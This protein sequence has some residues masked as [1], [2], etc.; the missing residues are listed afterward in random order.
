MQQDRWRTAGL[1]PGMAVRADI[2][3]P[4]AGCRAVDVIVHIICAHRWRGMGVG[5]PTVR[6]P[7]TRVVARLM[8][9][10]SF[11]LL[12]PPAP[13]VGLGAHPPS[14]FPPSVATVRRHGV[15]VHIVGAIH[16]APTSARDVEETVRAAEPSAVVLEL[17]GPRWSRL[18]DRIAKERAG[19]AESC[20]PFARWFRSSMKDRRRLG[21]APAIVSA[22][23]SLPYAAMRAPGSGSFTPGGEFLAWIGVGGRSNA[24]APPPAVVLGDVDAVD[25]LTG[26]AAS[27]QLRP[28]DGRSVGETLKHARRQFGVLG[29]ALGFGG[30][31]VAL[32]LRSAMGRGSMLRDLSVL[33]F[34]SLVVLAGIEV[35]FGDSPQLE[36]EQQLEQAIVLLNVFLTAWAAAAAPDAIATMLDE[37]DDGLATSIDAACHEARRD[38]TGGTPPAIVAVVGLL[39]VNGIAA[40][41]SRPSW[42]EAEPLHRD[43]RRATRLQAG[44]LLV[45]A[46][47]MESTSFRRSVLLLVKPVSSDVAG[48]S[49]G[50]MALRL[51]QLDDKRLGRGIVGSGGPCV[52]RMSQLHRSSV[53]SET[54]DGDSAEMERFRIHRSV[55]T[56]REGDTIIFHWGGAPLV[57]SNEKSADDAACIELDGCAAWW[58]GQL[59]AETAGGDWHVVDAPTDASDVLFG[60]SPLNETSLSWTQLAHF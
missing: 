47:G 26:L 29:R 36:V 32:N 4:P 57:I 59:E 12:L 3:A 15:D 56:A 42:S 13:C 8:C 19:V 18:L 9:L 28:Y 17:C 58:P 39:H 55:S 53:P 60:L 45:A 50:W 37:R 14:A 43:W 33:L 41:L 11:L 6:I 49:S 46:E 20:N 35:V 21:V 2:S 31:G 7:L 24:T 16:S 23:L 38:P 48:G 44:R 5:I 1:T 27:I 40:R 52:K 22:G 30:D 54:S 25:T 51:D 10:L 34:P